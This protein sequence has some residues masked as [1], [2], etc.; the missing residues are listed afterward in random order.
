[1][2][3]LHPIVNQRRHYPSQHPS[4]RKRPNNQQDNQSRTHTCNVVDNRMFNILPAHPIPAHSQSRTQGR[5][6]QQTNLAAATQRV[7]PQQ[8]NR[9]EK[10]YH[11]HRYRQQRHQ[12]RRNLH[13]LRH[14]YPFKSNFIT[15]SITGANFRIFFQFSI[16][17]PYIFTF[18]TTEMNKNRFLIHL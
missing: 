11:Q 13:F 6:Q 9:K 3:N 17:N 15:K 14:F 10:Q 16:Q 1:M 5:S 4:C 12:R 2:N 18:Y 7:S 8:T